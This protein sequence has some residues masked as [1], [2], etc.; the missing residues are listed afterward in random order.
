MSKLSHRRNNPGYCVLPGERE[1]ATTALHALWDFL[2]DPT[3]I[4]SSFEARPRH[5]RSLT[6]VDAFRRALHDF[7]AY[8]CI[9]QGA[10]LV[11]RGVAGVRG[12][13]SR[14]R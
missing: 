14:L 1:M 3:F 4:E 6:T 9:D 12:S 11:D 13:K 10:D 2:F 7:F 8:V 5:L